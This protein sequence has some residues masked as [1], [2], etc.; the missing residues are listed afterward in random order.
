MFHKPKYEYNAKYNDQA[1]KLY[2]A[3]FFKNI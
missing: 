2:A 3:F 1:V